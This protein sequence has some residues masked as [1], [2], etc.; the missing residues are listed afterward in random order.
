MNSTDDEESV[1]QP[2]TSTPNALNGSQL[3]YE[4]RHL[5][6]QFE[7]MK[8][9]CLPVVVFGIVGNLASLWIWQAQVT[10]NPTTFLHKY[11]AIADLGFLLGDLVLLIQQNHFWDFSWT[12]L[13]GHLGRLFQVMSVHATLAVAVFRYQ[14]IQI[15]LLLFFLLLLSFSHSLCVF[16]SVSVSFSVCQSVC[17]SLC[18]VGILMYKISLTPSCLYVYK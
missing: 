14:Y 18:C 16:L 8:T 5:T 4:I 17:L 1:Q 3:S 12:A 13:P 10:F 2:T 9:G 11:L 6:L 7:L 15:L